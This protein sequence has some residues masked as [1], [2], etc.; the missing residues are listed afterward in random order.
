MLRNIGR[1][2]NCVAQRI[3]NAIVAYWRIS[4][5]KAYLL[6]KNNFAPFYN[7]KAYGSVDVRRHTFLT[8]AL[9][10]GG[11]SADGTFA[12]PLLSR[13]PSYSDHWMVAWVA[14][15]RR[16]SFLKLI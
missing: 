10:E 6:E 13:T 11:L 1:R 9:D 16:F 4:I 14:P 12:V 3:V 2:F 15:N 8:S 5:H 7:M